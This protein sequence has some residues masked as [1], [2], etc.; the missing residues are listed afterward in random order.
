VGRVPL[1]PFIPVFSASLRKDRHS[2]LLAPSFGTSNDKGFTYRQPIFW[3]I[4]D[5][6]DLTLVPTYFEKRGL[7][8]GG[9][10]RYIRRETSRGELE[11]FGLDDTERKE[12]RGV[13][14]FRHEEELTPGSSSGRTSPGSATTTTSGT[15][16]TCSTAQPAAAGV[17]LFADRPLGAGTCSAGSSTRCERPASRSSCSACPRSG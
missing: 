2:G 6:Q 15:S 7:A 14:G 17:N 3:A 11:G 5:S 13:V 1:I 9:S 8:L 12:M 10:Y 16:A 4:S